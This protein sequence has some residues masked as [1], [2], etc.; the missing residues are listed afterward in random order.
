MPL[1]NVVANSFSSQDAVAFGWVTFWPIDFT[2]KGYQAVFDYK[3][4][5]TAYGNTFIYAILGTAINLSMTMICVSM[6][7]VIIT[8]HQAFL[9]KE[10]LGNIAKTTLEN[11][12]DMLENGFSAKNCGS[13]R[14]SPCR[15]GC[16]SCSSTWRFSPTP[17]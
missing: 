10:A 12:S 17:S 6:P 16:C 3:G 7:N 14:G 1:I 9:T 2:F 15:W 4:I 5:W 11:I 13:W 8:S